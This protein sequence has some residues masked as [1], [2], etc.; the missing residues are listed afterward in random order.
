AMA[1][2]L[3]G[4]LNRAGIETGLRQVLQ[5][6]V[7]ERGTMSIAFVDLD[8]FKPVNDEH[9]HGVGDQCLRIVSQ[10]VRDQLRE[11]DLIGRYGGDEFLV[12]M[13]ATTEAEAIA[14]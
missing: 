2:R 14:V 7:T 11:G 8:D 12:V 10:R 4:L 5:S 9:G 6:T 13:P 1:D 3:T